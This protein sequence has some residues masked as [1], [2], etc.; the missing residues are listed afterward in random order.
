[1]DEKIN[2]KVK[3]SWWQLWLGGVGLAFLFKNSP[4]LILGDV[5]AVFGMGWG[6][7]IGVRYLFKKY[8]KNKFAKVG[9]VVGLFLII[10]LIFYLL[11]LYFGEFNVQ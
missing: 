3:I 10:I 4:L 11:R 6:I 5:L 2:K 9:I 7:L 8:G 1:M